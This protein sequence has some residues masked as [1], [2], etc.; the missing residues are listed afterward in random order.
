MANSVAAAISSLLSTEGGGGGGGGAPPATTAPPRAA[1]RRG[2]AAASTRR[3]RRSARRGPAATAAATT[4][5]IPPTALVMGSH[6]V[7]DVVWQ[8]GRRESGVAASALLPITHLDDH[9]FWPDDLVL[10]RPVDDDDAGGATRGWRP[11][12]RSGVV[13][14]VDAAERTA[15]VAWLT[16]GDDGRLAAPDPATA[17]VVPVYS[18]RP[19]PDW[20][21]AHGDVVV[22]LDGGGGSGGATRSPPTTPTVGEVVG[23]AGGRVRVAWLGVDGVREEAPDELFV[24][25]REDDG[26]GGPGGDGAPPPTTIGVAPYMHYIPGGGGSGDD[27]YETASS[28]GDRSGGTASMPDAPADGDDADGADSVAAHSE[29]GDAPAADD[30][31]AP[32]APPTTTH[33]DPALPTDWAPFDVFEGDPPP[34]HAI[35]RTR[36]PAS[37]TLPRRFAKAVMKEW[38]ALR[39]GLPAGHIW[40]RAWEG[41][42]DALRAAVVGPPGTPYVG[43]IFVFDVALPPDYP[44]TPPSVS[45]HAYGHRVNPNLY[46]CGK[47]CLSLLGTWAG[48]EE[49]RWSP[50]TSTLL[51]VLVSIQGLVLV[52]EPYYNEAGYEKQAGSAEG[53]KNSRLYSESAFLVCA[54]TARALLRSPP[55]AFGPLVRAHYRQAREGLLAAASAYGEGRAPVGADVRPTAPAAFRPAEGEDAPP[56]PSRG[57]QLAMAQLLPSLRA[58]LEGI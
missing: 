29:G 4:G 53:A 34:D 32:A 39:A 16:R 22:R 12:P 51:Q 43:N 42:L 5:A 15:A 8:D 6:T 37:T 10:E 2:A 31:A 13:L 57:F 30:A 40:V 56:P 55:G 21:F 25:S 26:P 58:A 7:A 45:Y 46:E 47:V 48:R 17:T 1:S 49:E 41:R 27:E 33:E 35:F 36:S 50:A 11:S 9:D 3:A 23:L 18:I 38:D 24:L 52:S 19:H 54:R 20:A 44:A 14:S 28:D